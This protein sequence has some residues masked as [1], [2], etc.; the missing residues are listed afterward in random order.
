MRYK[1]LLASL[2]LGLGS[3]F[4]AQPT[5]AASTFKFAHNMPPKK[6]ASYHLLYLKFEELAKKYTGGEVTFR[7]FPSAQLGSDQKAAKKLQ[8]GTIEMM[9]VASNNIA[10]FYGGF[11]LFTLPFLFKS[12]E[13]GIDHVLTDDGLLNDI[14]AGAQ[15]K[16][17]MRVLAFGVGGMRN[18]MNSK[19]PILKPAD[20]KG[21]RMR[22]AK[23]PIQLDTYKA[24]GADAIG[25]AAKETYG[26][27][28]TRVVDGHDGG[29]SWAFAHKLYEVQKYIS[30]TG[31][32]MVV[33]SVIVNNKSFEKLSKKSQ[34]GIA[35]AAREAAT[36][37][38]AW[39]KGN[40]GKIIDHFVKSGLKLSR[41]DL[42][43]FQTA[44]KP[45]WDKYAKRVGG[46]DRINK[47]QAL[48]KQCK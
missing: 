11:D 9:A 48:Q 43:P 14:S 41:P 3:V 24:L 30:I 6:N 27:L 20:L 5:L 10:K 36:E 40:E 25:I 31:H 15:K 17:N 28:Q 44:V 26:S 1:I 23:N 16:A 18:I 19:K 37:N 32:Q 45:V 21:V 42:T 7:E 13:C 22:V 34:D 38:M 12:L 46:W 47:V 2:I 33:Y 29:S 4:I 8:L 39:M 35:R